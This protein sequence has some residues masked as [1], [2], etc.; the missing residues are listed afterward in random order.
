MASI[1]KA[2]LL[3]TVANNAGVSKKDAEAV[4]GAFFDSAIRSCEEGRQGRMAGLRFLRGDP[5]GGHH[6]PQPTDG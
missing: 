3:D 2:D 6:R 1:T 4:L 5:E